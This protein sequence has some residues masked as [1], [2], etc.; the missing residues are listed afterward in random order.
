VMPPPRRKRPESMQVPPRRAHGPFSETTSRDADLNPLSPF[1][2]AHASTDTRVP[3][4]PMKQDI[5]ATDNDTSNTSPPT[6]RLFRELSLS[7]RSDGQ[8]ER[9]REAPFAGLQRTFSALHQRAQPSLARARYKAEA[10][11]HPKRGFVP[12][13]THVPLSKSR[14]DLDTGNSD[15]GAV[16]DSDVEEEEREKEDGAAINAHL[17]SIKMRDELGTGG[18]KVEM[19]SDFGFLRI[20]CNGSTGEDDKDQ[21]TIRGRGRGVV[22]R[23]RDM[24]E[25]RERGD[26]KVERDNLKLPSGDGWTPL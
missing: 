4:Y 5:N 25:Q 18:A 23:R 17:D 2:N 6:T 7:S 11:L 14:L 12:S 22:G 21:E 3:T 24:L 19:G 8:R 1:A 16:V 10:G 26:W 15:D 20:D 13:P 9:E